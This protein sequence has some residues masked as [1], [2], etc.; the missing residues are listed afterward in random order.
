[1]VPTFKAARHFLRRVLP[2][3][4]WELLRNAGLFLYAQWPRRFEWIIYRAE[5]FAEP[6]SHDLTI[7]VAQFSPPLTPEQRAFM[8]RDLSPASVRE[9]MRR[10]RDGW[11]C[12]YFAK[13]EGQY[14][15]YMFCKSLARYR[16]AVPE[17]D[18]PR[19][20]LIGPGYTAPEFRGRNIH[21]RV[22]Q[23]AGCDAARRGYG[24]FFGFVYPWN[25]AANK[26]MV[27]AGWQR[28]GLWSVT[29]A[30]QHRWLRCRRIAD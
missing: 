25:D 11:E 23:Y 13:T 4:L 7:E 30:L 21:A 22:M 5:Q 27:K 20:C 10:F 17:L 28:I 2:A 18:L 15:D 3:P 1:V 16:R 8:L 29:A 12:V 24:P 26:A 19:A 14:C 6:D 9:N